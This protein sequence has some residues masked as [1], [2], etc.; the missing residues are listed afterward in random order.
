[1]EE[2]PYSQLHPDFRKLLEAMRKNGCNKIEIGPDGEITFSYLE[3]VSSP[4]TLVGMLAK[5]NEISES[6]DNQLAFLNYLEP[7]K[8]GGDNDRGRED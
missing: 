3:G 8:P 2:I 1:M 7:L 4:L 5:S 6:V